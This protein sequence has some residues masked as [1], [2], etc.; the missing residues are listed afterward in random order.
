[1]TANQVVSDNRKKNLHQKDLS[2]I[3]LCIFTAINKN[4]EKGN[5]IQFSSFTA[6]KKVPQHSA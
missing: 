4:Y 3:Q 2:E 5:E 6:T 1:M